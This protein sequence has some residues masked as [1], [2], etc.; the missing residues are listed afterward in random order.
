MSCSKKTLKKIRYG[1]TGKKKKIGVNY[2]RFFFNGISTETS[3]EQRFFIEFET[4]NPWISPKEIQ[5][6]YRTRVK[7]NA[8]DLQYALAGTESAKNLQTE[9]IVQPSY[10]AVR[11]GCLGNVTKQL[12]SYYPIKDINFNPK[13]FGIEIGNK[14]FSDSKLSGFLNVSEENLRE[15]PELLCDKGNASWTLSYEIQKEAFDG[16]KDNGNQ[17]VPCGLKTKFAGKINFDG[18]DYIVDPRRS[19]GYVDKYYGDDFTNTWFH[20]SASNLTSIISGGHLFNSCFAVQGIADEKVSLLGCF[21]GIDINLC[22][23]NNKN[24]TSIWSCVQTP[25]SDDE[26]ENQ[27]HWSTSVHNKN[28]VVDVDLYCKLTDLVNRKI[29][30]A[31]GNRKILSILE[32]GNCNGEIKLYKKNKNDLEQIENAKI[33]KAICQ[34]GKIEEYDH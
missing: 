17:W 13:Q 28:W 11:V 16:F 18:I 5:L 27:L 21:E 34:F 14:F 23:S 6:G 32:S 22:Q 30:L 7:I 26:N 8:A 33:E 20:I 9:S 29:E 12:V 4:L 19:Y 31:C 2:L 3:Q 25:E 10:C 24:F 1:F 15:A